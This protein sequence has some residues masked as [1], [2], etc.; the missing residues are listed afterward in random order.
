MRRGSTIYAAPPPQL[1]GFM[2]RE[3]LITQIFIALVTN[4]EIKT[5]ASKA[6][7]QIQE[8]LDLF[9]AIQKEL[10]AARPARRKVDVGKLA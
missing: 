6:A 8:H 2:K 5:G 10:K 7:K 3:E 9:D 4:G 1:E